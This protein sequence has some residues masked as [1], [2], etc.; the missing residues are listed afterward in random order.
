P[1]QRKK[2]GG[3]GRGEPPRTGGASHRIPPPIIRYHKICQRCSFSLLDE[4]GGPQEEEES[5]RGGAVPAQ[6]GDRLQ[7]GQD[8]L[9]G[10]SPT[11]SLRLTSTRMDDMAKRGESGTRPVYQLQMFCWV[12]TP[13]ADCLFSV[14]QMFLPRWMRNQKKKRC[15]NRTW[16]NTNIKATWRNTNIRMPSIKLPAPHL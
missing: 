16:H 13:K 5:F 9:D 14:L 8:S 2:A 12:K 6:L 15:S 4:R 3:G 7:D 1:P 10:T 11:R